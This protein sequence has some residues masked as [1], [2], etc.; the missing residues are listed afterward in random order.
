MRCILFHHRVHCCLSGALAGQS[1][2]ARAVKNSQGSRVQPWGG[3]GRRAKQHYSHLPAQHL[4]QTQPRCQVCST[5]LKLCSSGQASQGHACICFCSCLRSPYS[6]AVWRSTREAP[7][8]DTRRA[9]DVRVSRSKLSMYRLRA[10]FFWLSDE[11]L[12]LLLLLACAASAACCLSRWASS[13][14]QDSAVEGCAW[15]RRRGAEFPSV[16]SGCLGGC[17]RLAACCL[18]AD[19]RA[20]RQG[21]ATCGA[22]QRLRCAPE[23]PD[24][25]WSGSGLLR[26]DGEATHLP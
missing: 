18:T 2:P 22:E 8:V 15:V 4:S 13:S 25:G 5:Q 3:P 1:Q 9:M 19:P 23:V 24:W 14:A 6:A 10:P 26:W 20:C 7:S 21:C 16:L 17:S 11:L 12:L